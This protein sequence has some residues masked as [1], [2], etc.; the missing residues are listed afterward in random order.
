MGDSELKHVTA[1][2]VHG[3]ALLVLKDLS[4]LVRGRHAQLDPGGAE[5]P[6]DLSHLLRVRQAGAADDDVHQVGPVSTSGVL[7]R[8]VGDLQGY[9]ALTGGQAVRQCLGQPAAQLVSHEDLREL[10]D[11][12]V[13]SGGRGW[14]SLAQCERGCDQEG[15]RGYGVVVTEPAPEPTLSDVI[16]LMTA[17]FAQLSTAQATTNANLESQRRMLAELSSKVAF[18]EANQSVQGTK[19]A[20][21][22]GQIR[23]GFEAAARDMAALRE[24]IAGVKSDMAFVEGFNR[25]MHEALVRHIADPN[26]HPDAA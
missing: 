13:V 25:D 20:E 5:L 2:G 14:R 23:G 15:G 12:V 8:L 7:V 3:P 11:G 26:A 24:D 1:A 17:G 16:A 19:Q 22:A 6:Q 10:V 21:L 18:V 9:E 4:G